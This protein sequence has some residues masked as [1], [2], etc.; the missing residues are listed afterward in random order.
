ML[1]KFNQCAHKITNSGLYGYTS[2]YK[3][4]LFAIDIFEGIIK[5]LLLVLDFKTAM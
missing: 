5:I 2:I 3:I 1:E 4:H